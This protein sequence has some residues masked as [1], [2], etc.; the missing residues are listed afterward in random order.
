MLT[1]RG[2]VQQRWHRDTTDVIG[3]RRLISVFVA[4]Q[5]TDAALG[6]TRVRPGSHLDTEPYSSEDNPRS[7][8][9]EDAMQLPAGGAL[10]PLY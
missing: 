8:T 7:A 3:K 6:A 1:C 10:T 4:L 9:S 5:D 2:S